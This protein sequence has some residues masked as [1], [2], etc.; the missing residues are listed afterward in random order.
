VLLRENQ[1]TRDF[2]LIF[3]FDS[4][5]LIFS[6][7]KFFH[8]FGVEAVVRKIYCGMALPPTSVAAKI[9]F[10]TTVITLNVPC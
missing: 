6:L 7:V 10:T 4:F 9:Y 2:L 8:I 1:A 5:V 3:F